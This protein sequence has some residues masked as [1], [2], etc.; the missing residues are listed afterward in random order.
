[1]VDFGDTPIVGNRLGACVSDLCSA[2]CCST[3]ARCMPTPR[4]APTPERR[5]SS[6]CRTRHTIRG[7]RLSHGRKERPLKYGTA[8][9][10]STCEEKLTKA[11]E[12][13]EI[14]KIEDGPRHCSTL[15][16]EGG[17]TVLE[18][19]RQS[20]SCETLLGLFVRIG[21]NDRQ[22]VDLHIS[23]PHHPL[24][25]T[26]RRLGVVVFSFTLRSARL[27]RRLWSLVPRCAA[28]RWPDTW[29][30]RRPSW[31]RNPT[32]PSDHTSPMARGRS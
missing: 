31:L 27:R 4:W 19:N 18:K 24:A 8:R 1:M 28:L 21:T 17:G 22:G 16:E 13:L 32:C 10:K 3:Q 26:R 20:S 7:Q 30:A 25:T 29:D 5:S 6:L 23:H 11:Q 12:D 15:G 2:L 9:S 14:K